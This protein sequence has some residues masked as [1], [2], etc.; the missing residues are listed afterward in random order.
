M[1][2]TS[3]TYSEK[4]GD[5]VVG[6]RYD[7]L[8]AA[9]AEKAKLHIL[10]SIG[11]ALAARETEWT[12]LTMEVA[13]AL[14][15]PA[16]SRVIGTKYR[17][18]AANAALVNGTMIHG[19]DFDDTYIPGGLHVGC[20]VVPAVVAV[21]EARAASGR[22][23]LEAT[24]AAY[25]VSCR[26]S[27]AAFDK[28]TGHS[29]FV[30]RGFHTAGIFAAMGAAAAAAKIMGMDADAVA[31][32]L[33]IAASQSSG[34]FQ[35]QLEG[36]WV[37]TFHPGWGAHGGI[38]ASH[39]AQKGFS[40]PHRIF[41][42]EFGLF[43]AFLGS[44]NYD[45]ED[46]TRGLGQKWDLL[47]VSFK[48]YPAG[49][50]THFFLE[51]ALHLQRE[52]RLEAKN[53]AEVRCI[54]SPFRVHAHFEPRAVKYTPTN[55]Y[56]AR[57]SLPYL[58]ALRLLQDEVGLDDFSEERLK[59]PEVLDLASR[60]TYAVDAEADLPEN[61]GHVIIR[62]KDGQSYEHKQRAI[63]GTPEQ[64]AT[65]E[66]IERKFRLNAKQVLPPERIEAVINGLRGLETLERVEKLMDL[67]APAEDY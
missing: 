45:L 42:G 3:A 46:L 8:P 27:R 17:F 29:R 14:G 25:E 60:V 16:E 20:F 19:L 63:P 40:A 11:I 13:K 49:H 5:F 53:I 62:T 47:D 12:H 57:F 54:V 39:L 41:E 66:E 10:D 9:V 21:A 23:M 35:T 36:T 48:L 30:D 52:H 33:G 2:R 15:G 26:M 61:R 24:V 31:G 4:L 64:P 28:S 50:G 58:L 7:A 65:R 56:I 44:G 6:L 43:N 59:H 34:L 55:S 37:K 1:R 51:S 38:I 18:P 67:T 22:A 32:A